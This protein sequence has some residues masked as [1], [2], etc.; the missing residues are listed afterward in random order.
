MTRAKIARIKRAR[1]IQRAYFKTFGIGFLLLT[2]LLLLLFFFVEML[3][4]V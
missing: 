1:I 4:K 2:L 3:T